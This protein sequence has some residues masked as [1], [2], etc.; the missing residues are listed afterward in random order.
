MYTA[1]LNQQEASLEILY[2]SLGSFVNHGTKLIQTIMHVENLL[3]R[4][5]VNALCKNAI[6]L[7]N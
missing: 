5:I 3:N 1:G 7:N 2:L 4:Y 6:L